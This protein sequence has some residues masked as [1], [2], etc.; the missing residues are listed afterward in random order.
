MPLSAPVQ[1]IS[2]PGPSAPNAASTIDLSGISPRDWAIY[3]LA[4]RRLRDL[5]G[6]ARLFGD[7]AWDILLEVYVAQ[8]DGKPLNVSSASAAG[9][10]PMATGIRWLR[11]LAH[12]GLLQR[13]AD[14]NDR[15]VSWVTLTAKG[16]AFVTGQLESQIAALRSLL[17]AKA[18]GDRHPGA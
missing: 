15:R 1:R 5:P 18:H 10:L 3:L 14:V 17:A 6:S 4:M 8:G 2:A 12:E 13:T 9:A 16:E 11:V 7:P